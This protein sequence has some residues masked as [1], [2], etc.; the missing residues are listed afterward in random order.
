[1][2]DKKNN[3]S[4]LLIAILIVFSLIPLNLCIGKDNTTIITIGVL[5]KRG[6]SICMKRWTPTAKYLTGRIP[7]KTFKIVPLNFND[8]V[9]C[10]QNGKCDFVLVNPVFYVELEKQFGVDRIATLRNSYLDHGYT[11][12]GGTVFCRA[13]ETEIKTFKDLK[14]K[15]CA[16]PDP[17]AFGS[18][19][20]VCRE[21]KNAGINPYKDFKTVKFVHTMDAVV[22]A[23]KNKIADAG[24]VR[25]DILEHM[26]A[27]HKIN[28]KNFRI[29]GL[30]K[31][32]VKSVKTFPF[33]RSTRLY[34]E[35]PFAA[36]GHVS[37]KLAKQVALALIAMPENSHAARAAECKGWTIPLNYQHVHECLKE[38]KLGPYKNSGN[39]N[40][41][42]VMKKYWYFIVVFIVLIAILT[43]ALIVF[44]IFNQK[45]KASNEKLI[46][47][48]TERRQKERELL[49]AQKQLKESEARLKNVFQASPLG[50]T[51]VKNRRILWHNDNMAKMSGY[52]SDEFYGK[53]ARMLYTDDEEFERVGRVIN[54]L[55]P[56][57]KTSEIETR[58]VRK[59]GSEFDCHIRYALIEPEKKDSIVLAIVDDITERKK[60]DQEK[61]KL[62][63][64]LNQA[65]KMESI[66]ILA[67]G[68]AHD[69]NNILTSI[70]G[71]ADLILMDID[72]NSD[73]Y[74]DIEE[75]R[76]AG[77]RAATLT[78]QLLAFSRKQIISP[79]IMNLNKTV[80]SLEKMLH[81]LIGEDIDLII[82]CAPDL[83]HI[84]AD[85]GQMEQIVMNLVVNARDALPGGGEIIIETLDTVLDE[86]YFKNHAVKPCIGKY[87]M[88]AITDNGTGMDEKTQSRIFEPFFTTKEMG[89][90][91]G[92]GL[93]TVYGIVKQNNGHVWVYSE[94]N[95]GTTFKIYLPAI[96]D[97]TNTDSDTKT[98]TKISK[99]C[100]GKASETILIAED[101]DMLRY[102]TKKMLEK[103]G[104]T[105]FTAKNGEE[106]IK[107]VEACNIPIDLLL[108]DV[109][110]PGMNGKTLARHIKTKLSNIKVVYTSGYTANVIAHHGVLGEGVSFI[111]KPF[112][113]EDLLDKIHEELSSD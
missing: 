4:N 18:W 48:I 100:S 26:T 28:I 37:D 24:S 58:W 106:A 63:A 65:Q 27:E 32:Q 62:R 55:G 36:T 72:K 10:V 60:A 66:G 22:Y 54:S 73:I 110:M 44:L 56:N 34:P 45:I 94:K 47:E 90:G 15:I 38:L 68:I 39:M 12:F 21:L 103:A 6:N 79:E 105:V 89:H 61:E 33:V 109:V 67:G 80:T 5:A 93:S 42:E 99:K 41:K 7:G 9:P 76:K 102:M 113:Q 74:K 91:T 31:K 95:K 84:K 81:R 77:Q 97:E 107:F 82:K 29:I 43:G 98:I 111:Q 50:I 49:A 17:N 78:R 20:A 53:N 112:R 23:V 83:P 64:Q 1:M 57:K 46:L 104:Y 13:D 16:A 19:I 88:L 85:P 86:K 2:L 35:W 71:N 14:G 8:V 3:K 59:D 101:D 96:T 92:L 69:F 40:F 51:L 30:K 87:V 70:I 11:Q 108:T 75:I 52:S 25:T